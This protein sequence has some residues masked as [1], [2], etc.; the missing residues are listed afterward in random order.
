MEIGPAE[1]DSVPDAR[2][3]ADPRQNPKEKY[4]EFC[5]A[6]IHNTLVKKIINFYGKG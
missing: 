5:Q 4:L 2:G 6:L 1:A 3:S